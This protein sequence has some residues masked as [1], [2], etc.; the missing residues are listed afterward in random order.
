MLRYSQFSEGYSFSLR[1]MPPVV[2][3]THCLQVFLTWPSLWWSVASDPYAS[4]IFDHLP[5]ACFRDGKIAPQV[6]AHKNL[7]FATHGDLCSGQS[8]SGLSLPARF[9]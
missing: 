6:A 9:G 7:M 4:Q 2:I 8:H 5:G 1:W 3:A